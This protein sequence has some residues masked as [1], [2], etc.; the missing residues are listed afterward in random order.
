MAD[1]PYLD[2]KRY[3]PAGEVV[4]YRTGWCSFCRRLEQQLVAEGIGATLVDIER[5]LDAEAFVKQV[6]HGDAVVPTVLYPDGS[7]ETNP[8]I[9]QV[10]A[11]LG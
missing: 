5:D 6:N 4:V 2:P 8:S 1:H 3:P 10:Q 11:R 7:V 9:K